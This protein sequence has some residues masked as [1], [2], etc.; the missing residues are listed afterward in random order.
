MYEICRKTCDDGIDATD[1]FPSHP[2]LMGDKYVYL[3][4]LYKLDIV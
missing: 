3:S 4:S 1:V 2:D